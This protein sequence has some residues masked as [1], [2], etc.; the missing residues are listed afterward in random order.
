[1]V[2]LTPVKKSASATTTPTTPVTVSA[3]VAAAEEISPLKQ[4]GQLDGQ[5]PTP[6][7]TP[8]SAVAST[9]GVGEKKETWSTQENP[10][11]AQK[12]RGDAT[13]KRHFYGR[14]W[15]GAQ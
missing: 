3:P 1:M 15:E 4:G 14:G 12:Y 13:E 11:N 7:P 9:S 10:Q 5:K 6:T 2:G 8:E